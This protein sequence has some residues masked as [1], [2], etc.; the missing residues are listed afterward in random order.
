MNSD[1]FPPYFYNS[2]IIQFDFFNSTV[3]YL[4][5]K[6]LGLGLELTQL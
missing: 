6:E 2:E 1:Y 4:C 5:K 3:G